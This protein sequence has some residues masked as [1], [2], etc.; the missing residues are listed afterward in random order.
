MKQLT[1]KMFPYTDD[2]AS[3]IINIVVASV[4]IVASAVGIVKMVT[5]L[6]DGNIG[7]AVES[8]A[9]LLVNG[10]CACWFTVSEVKRHRAARSSIKAEEREQERIRLLME[11]RE[12]E[13]LA[14]ARRQAQAQAE[15]LALEKLEEQLSSSTHEQVSLPEIF[16]GRRRRQPVH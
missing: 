1:K 11:Q 9:I 13:L 5:S 12:Q 10:L 2:L 4:N 8:G 16:A 3:M 7:D 6:L 14:E 15:Q